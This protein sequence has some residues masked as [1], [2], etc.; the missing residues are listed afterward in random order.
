MPLKDLNDITVST[1]QNNFQKYTDSISPDITGELKDWLD[2]FSVL[3]PREAKIFELGSATGRDARYL[4]TLGHH[5]TCTDV[6]GEAL[7]K[8]RD[9]GFETMHY[10]FRDV[11]DESLHNR[12][13]GYIADAVL[14]HAP[15]HIFEQ[16]LR[17]MHIIL[18][19][20]GIAMLVLKDGMGQEMT[21]DKMGAPRYFKYH[22]EE[23]LRIALGKMP[24]EILEI[25][26]SV[27]KKWLK[28]IVRAL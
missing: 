28:V 21:I 18:K 8:L 27:P 24:F 7:T 14:L 17:Y 12:Y 9:E 15:Q 2:S 26:P 20:G 11:P 6:I 5:V 4:S 3:L 22:N 23:S 25:L 16:A 1:Y 10:D 19:K 13:D